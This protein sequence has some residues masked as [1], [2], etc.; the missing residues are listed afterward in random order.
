MF[1]DGRVP[2]KC[3]CKTQEQSDLRQKMVG[4]SPKC[5]TSYDAS[6]KIYQ[7]IRIQVRILQILSVLLMSTIFSHS[8]GVTALIITSLITDATRAASITGSLTGSTP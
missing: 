4:I 2:L 3:Y 7:N 5:R 1:V 8:L 6:V